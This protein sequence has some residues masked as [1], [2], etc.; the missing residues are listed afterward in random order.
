MGL[1]GD[2]VVRCSGMLEQLRALDGVRERSPTVFYRSSKPFLHFHGR[3]EELVADLKT[4]DGWLRYSV[5]T[6]GSQRAVVSDARRVLR[7]LPV[8][9]GAGR[10]VP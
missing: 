7:G 8:R 6:K 2:D 9:S 10:G 1:Q 3:G 5:G 4:D